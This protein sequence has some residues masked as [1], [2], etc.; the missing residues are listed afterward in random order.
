MISSY[1]H[2]CVNCKHAN[3]HRALKNAKSGGACNVNTCKCVEHETSD[4]PPFKVGDKVRVGKTYDYDGLGGTKVI[5]SQV[6]VSDSCGSGY[7]I[8]AVF[9]HQCVCRDCG[10]KPKVS[11]LIG[12]DSSHFEKVK[13]KRKS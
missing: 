3:S 11:E 7:L 9:D 4:A 13:K 5:V 10:F 6:R 12:L 1:L 8:D 2:Y